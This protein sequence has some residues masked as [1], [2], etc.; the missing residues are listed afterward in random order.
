MLIL[1]LCFGHVLI[2]WNLIRFHWIELNHFICVE[3]GWYI[4]CV[5]YSNVL[6]QYPYA[7]VPLSRILQVLPT[8]FN[9]YLFYRFECGALLSNQVYSS[10]MKWKKKLSQICEWCRLMFWNAYSHTH[11]HTRHQTDTAIRWIYTNRLHSIPLKWDV[12][13]TKQFR[14]NSKTDAFSL[15]YYCVVCHHTHIHKQAI[16]RASEWVSAGKSECEFRVNLL[17]SHLWQRYFFQQIYIYLRTERDASTHE[18]TCAQAFK[19]HFYCTHIVLNIVSLNERMNDLIKCFS[20][21]SILLKL[22]TN[23]HISHTHSYVGLCAFAFVLKR[24]TEKD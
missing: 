16:K 5:Q 8:I 3:I 9:A 12:I 13:R 4:L 15:S 18:H 19:V 17:H 22:E 20:S 10:N 7:I 14:L 2:D 6:Y 1:Q 21:I 24:Q 11:T 23:T